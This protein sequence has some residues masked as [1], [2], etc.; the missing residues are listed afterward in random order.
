MVGKFCPNAKA[1]PSRIP[2][3][4]QDDSADFAD[5]SDLVGVCNEMAVDDAGWTVIP[6]GIH[7][8][9]M[10]MQQFGREE[11]TKIVGYFR[12]TWNRIKR[13]ITGLPVF[14]GHPDLP[15]M[16][17]Q[18]PDKTEY[19]QLAD[20]EIRPNGLAIKMVLSSAGAKLVQMGKKF[21][22]PHWLANETGQTADGKRIFSPVFMKSIGLTDTPNIPNPT[23][24][25]NSAVAE[26]SKNMNKEILIKLLGLANEA[27]EQ[28]IEA[29]I[30][31]LLKRPEPSALANEQTAR[32]VAEGNATSLANEN[33]VLKADLDGTKVAF[34]N[35]RKARVDG[36]IADAIRGGRITEAEKPVWEQRLTRDFD[37]ESKALVN[38]AIKVKTAAITAG[39][40]F[41]EAAAKL[42]DLALE[43]EDSDGDDAMAN[44]RAKIKSAI[45]DE[46]AKLMAANPKMSSSECHTKA[47]ANASKKHPKLF[48]AKA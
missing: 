11:A 2:K 22:S 24:L 48:G 46:K 40:A 36:L 15:S 10:G 32:T 3:E 19:G 6:Y 39:K 1:V 44:T 29:R 47:Y 21:I 23:S 7:P 41:E 43:N 30:A 9:S 26:S 4:G 45:S 20:M 27:N 34:A 38:S 14:N 31:D 16:A 42:K 12:G 35:E 5:C 25:L 18:Y 28:Q 13:A 37:L 17:N 33:K 8:H